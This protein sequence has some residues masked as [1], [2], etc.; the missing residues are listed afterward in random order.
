MSNKVQHTEIVKAINLNTIKEN[1][2]QC[3]IVI[4]TAIQNKVN[5]KIKIEEQ[6]MRDNIK[7][8]KKKIALMIQNILLIYKVQ[9]LI[10]K[11]IPIKINM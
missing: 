10:L 2:I 5:L 9:R 6:E 11:L 4:I 8:Y 1:P 3:M 7:N